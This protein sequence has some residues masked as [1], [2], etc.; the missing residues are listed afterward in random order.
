MTLQEIYNLTQSLLDKSGSPY[1]GEDAVSDFINLAINDFI[2]TTYENFEKN[3]EFRLRLQSLYVPFTI[4]NKREILLKTPELSNFRYL[5]HI[6]AKFDKVDCDGNN[7]EIEVNVRPAPMDSI[8]V[9]K[10]DPFNKPT[11]ED[12]IYYY[13]ANTS[14]EKVLYVLSTTI[15]KEVNGVYIKNPTKVDILANPNTQFQFDDKLALEICQLAVKKMEVN[16]ENYNR[17]QFE[18]AEIRQSSGS[19]I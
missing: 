17:A 11:D 6:S 5:T 15:P 10:K 16:I 2:E 1:F 8:D 4:F 18:A 3:Q 13:S 19:A 12:P 14:L 9:I 7:V